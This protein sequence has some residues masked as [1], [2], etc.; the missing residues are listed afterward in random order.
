[1][2]TL[3]ASSDSPLNA[4]WIEYDR[5]LD[6]AGVRVRA[7]SVRTTRSATTRA[8]RSA[9]A[10]SLA[11]HGYV[12]DRDDGT[13]Y[14]AP[15]ADVMLSDAFTNGHCFRLEPPTDSAPEEI[16]VAFRPVGDDDRRRDIS[17]VL[18]LDRLT[19]E[20]RRIEYRYTGLPALVERARPGGT[21][22][23]LRLGA[24]QWM[25]QRWQCLFR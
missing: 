14:H 2:D 16:G 6:S 15:D 18:W 3:L 17:G 7:Q 23:F 19:S 1:M 11:A 10:E 8:F 5:T 20:L 9:P 25:V 4:E 21:V 24:G 12:V 22:E 13:V